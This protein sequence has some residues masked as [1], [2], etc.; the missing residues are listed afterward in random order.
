MLEK[1]KERVPGRYCIPG[2]TEV[3]NANAVNAMS[4]KEKNGG[5]VDSRRRKKLM[6]ENPGM[7]GEGIEAIY[8]KQFGRRRKLTWYNRKYIMDSVNAWNRKIRSNKIK[9]YHR[10]IIG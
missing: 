2:Q 7:K 8:S 9:D 4:G 5:K 6:S 3:A 1:L 10:G